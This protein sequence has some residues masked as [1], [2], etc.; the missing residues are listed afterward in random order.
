MGQAR[1]AVDL[2][3]EEDMSLAGICEQAG[4]L[5]PDQLGVG[6]VLDIPSHD[7]Q[8]ALVREGLELVAGAL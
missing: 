5:W 2:L 1:Q 7:R 4:Q 3:D 8:A 6:L